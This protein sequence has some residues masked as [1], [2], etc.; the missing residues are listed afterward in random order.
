M[1]TSNNFTNGKPCS[2]SVAEGLV[3]WPE[4]TV[5][6]VDENTPLNDVYIVQ[7][8]PLITSLKNFSTLKFD[9]IVCIDSGIIIDGFVYPVSLVNKSLDGSC[10]ISTVQVNLGVIND[11]SLTFLDQNSCLINAFIRVGRVLVESENVIV[12][13]NETLSSGSVCDFQPI[14]AATGVVLEA[15]V[16]LII[17]DNTVNSTTKPNYTTKYYQDRGYYKPYEKYQ[18]T[19]Q[20]YDDNYYQK[21]NRNIRKSRV[22]GRFLKLLLLFFI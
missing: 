10:P 22:F 12:K 13:I 11:G 16:V 5:T 14:V 15:G 1:D 20:K 3:L 6:I 19:Y 17:P 21:R 9:H 4:T 2:S 18:Q 8:D 7:E